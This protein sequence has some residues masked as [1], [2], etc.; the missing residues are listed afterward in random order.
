[1]LKIII[2]LINTCESFLTPPLLLPL[3]WSVRPREQSTVQNIGT[4]R[5]DQRYKQVSLCYVTGTSLHYTPRRKSRIIQLNWGI[6]LVPILSRPHPCHLLLVYQAEKGFC[7]FL[8]IPNYRQSGTQFVPDAYN[9]MVLT[10]NIYSGKWLVAF[11]IM[12]QF[13]KFFF[14]RALYG[15]YRKQYPGRYRYV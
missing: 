1:M 11:I 14:V 12:I 6:E 4:G 8:H 10:E 9:I 2:Y 7:L 13:N 3:V 5:P 15:R